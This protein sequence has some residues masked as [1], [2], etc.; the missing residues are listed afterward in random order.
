M[1]EY[2]ILLHT[3]HL[4]HFKPTT[5]FVDPFNKT[6]SGK[7]I[8]LMQA[9]VSLSDVDSEEDMFTVTT[10]RVRYQ[11]KPRGEMDLSA[12]GWVEKIT[13]VMLSAGIE[14]PEDNRDYTDFLSGY[15]K[16][17]PELNPSQSQAG[18][19]GGPLSA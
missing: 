5:G 18:G 14:G 6:I 17:M 10:A 8:D 16:V 2:F 4:V 3:K 12:G 11:L 1:T 7:A 13:Q 15:N 9:K 19:I